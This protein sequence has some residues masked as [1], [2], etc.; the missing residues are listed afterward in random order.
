MSSARNNKKRF[1]QDHNI[2]LLTVEELAAL[3]Q[4]SVR[5]IWRQVSLGKIPKPKYIGRLA[6]W[7][8][9]VIEKWLDETSE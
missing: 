3:L 8:Q 2:H 6:R 7:R 4:V 9:A 5:S 1:H